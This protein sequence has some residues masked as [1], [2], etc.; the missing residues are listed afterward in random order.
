MKFDFPNDHTVYMHGTPAPLLFER[1][2][3]D[4]SHGCVRLADPAGLAEFV[5]AEADWS[6]G[7]I[8]AE[9]AGS[10]TFRHRLIH[11]VSVFVFYTTTVVRADGTVSF[12][13]DLYGEDRAL[14]RALARS[15]G[16]ADTVGAGG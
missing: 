16:K 13:D 14:R 12:F 10:R 3:R 5:I 7:R 6:R 9:M 1:A 2:R 11:P 8:E 15:A 4:F